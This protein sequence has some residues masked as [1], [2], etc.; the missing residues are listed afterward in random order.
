M[1]SSVVTE[2]QLPG[3]SIRLFLADGIPQGLIVAEVGNWT[4][5]ALAAPR[6][7]MA[8]LLRRAE[9]SR[10]GL[11][12]LM[13]PDPDKVDGV[14]AYTG[15]A[16]NVASRLRNHPRLEDKDFFDRL[17][18]IVSSDDNLTKGHVRYI[19]SQLIRIVREAGSVALTND[20]HPDFHRLPEADR[21][22]MD[23]FVAQLRVVLPILGCDLFRRTVPVRTPS[24]SAATAASGGTPTAGFAAAGERTVPPRLPGRPAMEEPLLSSP[25]Q[26]PEHLPAARKPMTA[27][28][29]LPARR[30]ARVRPARSRPVISL[31]ANSSSSRASWSMRPETRSIA[32]RWTPFRQP[33]R[34][35]LHRCGP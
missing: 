4:G 27:S 9:A 32:S 15:E 22:D 2:P 23:T 26:R 19:E 24:P 1:N 31:N 25:S 12:V 14:L 11:Y 21:A 8:E 29:F 28:S 10:T 17:V 20:T 7:R 16:D 3:R 34:R 30:P 5:K 13:G 33:Q 18:I 35:S 6:S